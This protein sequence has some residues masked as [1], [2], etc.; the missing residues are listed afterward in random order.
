M[1]LSLV[2]ALVFGAGMLIAAQPTV[3]AELT[4]HLGSPTA[5]T[6]VSLSVSVASVLPFALL[7][8]R[9]RLDA[10]GAVP[11]WAWFGGLAGSAF[12]M[13]GLLFVP[14]VGAAF[15]LVAAITGQLVAAAVIDHYGL[16]NT[17]V[18]AFDATRA[19]G[20]ALVVAGVV[21]FRLGRG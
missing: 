12:V 17:S 6:L 1:P 2:L 13:A 4:R 10:L 7:A 8:D 14:R 18:R 5:A 9:P 20:L 15:F 16:F 3:N 11:V 19:I 21:V